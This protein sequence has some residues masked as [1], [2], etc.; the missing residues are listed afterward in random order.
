M[1]EDSEYTELSPLWDALMQG[2]VKKA[3]SLCDHG[4]D[5]N[6]LI[7]Q[8]SFERVSP[9]MMA[10]QHFE[11]HDVEKMVEHGADINARASGTGMS[12]VTPLTSAILADSLEKVNYLVGRGATVNPFSSGE[13]NFSPLALA[14]VRGDLTIFDFLLSQKADPQWRDY[15]NATILKIAVNNEGTREQTRIVKR[16]IELGVNPNEPDNEGFFPL[17]NAAA[18]GRNQVME[19]LIHGGALLDQ[20][21]V[22]DGDDVGQ[23][24]LRK[25]ATKGHIDAVNLLLSKGAN[26]N[27][28]I[29]EN[30]SFE[31]LDM[32][33]GMEEGLSE[34]F[35]ILSSILLCCFQKTAGEFIDS[36]YE[37][38]ISIF[39]RAGAK[40]TMLT[41]SY[42]LL[43][44]EEEKEQRFL[45][46]TAEADLKEYL[47][48]D[49]LV[50]LLMF[51]LS[52]S[53]QH[54]I[55]YRL[56]EIYD[57]FYDLLGEVGIDDNI[58]S[59]LKSFVDEI[60]EHQQT[61]QKKKLLMII[62]MKNSMRFLENISSIIMFQLLNF[63][64]QKHL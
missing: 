17:H 35:D 29:P 32:E 58:L 2:E 15:K 40:P 31:I 8:G 60:K 20:Q 56:L 55:E 1:S 5:I 6:E 27:L 34:K 13:A 44:T 62:L 48:E 18:L 19:V 52:L 22:G 45:F 49:S 53:E 41:L 37:E 61:G 57:R 50:L 54:G 39:C 12:I 46:K 63:L 7:D 64:K 10:A 24:P 33:K 59:V 3:L 26:V 30:Q 43:F 14:A 47:T 23:R 4:A 38:I 21:I 11:L 51:V 9:L 42:A 36:G 16:L 28:I 25:A